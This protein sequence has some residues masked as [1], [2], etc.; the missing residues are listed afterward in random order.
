[1]SLDTFRLSDEQIKQVQE[2]FP[3]SVTNVERD[4]A[5]CAVFW[6]QKEDALSLLSFLKR[7][8]SL[9][10]EFLSDL[11]AYDEKTS[12]EEALS[13]FVMVYNLYSPS[14]K[15]RARVKVRLQENEEM[16]TAVGLWAGANWAERE[17][18]DLFG[19]KFSG[20]PDLRRILLDIRW[21][22]HPL[23]KDYPI[24]QYQLFNDAEPMPMD[25]LQEG[26]PEHLKE[27]GV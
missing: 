4:R 20:H 21:E 23:R 11:T 24:R 8:P 18:Y 5:G 6:V 9:E 19:I 12:R 13:R 25:L 27:K 15:F 17:V 26:L 22:G 7:T 3:S 16:P 1:M 10:F 14:T 2:H